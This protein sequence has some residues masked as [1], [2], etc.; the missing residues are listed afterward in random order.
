M[1][2]FYV[3]LSAILEPV[4]SNR[5]AFIDNYRSMTSCLAQALFSSKLTERGP[6]L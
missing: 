5:Q 2:D 1:G 4:N 6:Y 3:K